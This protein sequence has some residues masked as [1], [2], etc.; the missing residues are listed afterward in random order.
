VDESLAGVM[1]D[2]TGPCP[3]GGNLLSEQEK[4]DMATFLERVSYPPARSRRIDDSLSRIGEGVVVADPDGG[5]PI[6]VGALEG[7]QDFFLDQNGGGNPDTCAD[8]NA[9]CHELPLGAATN[10]ETLQAFDA[11]T[12]RGMTDR[13]LQFSLGPAHTEELLGLLNFGFPPQISP[14]EAPI[15]WDPGQGFREITTFGAA[16]AI[17]EPIYGVRP[18]ST[19]PSGALGRQVTLNSR[20]T[21]PAL[22][23]E[24]EAL[25]AELEAADE[26]GV[27]NLRGS[28]LRNGQIVKLSYLQ[29]TDQYK[30]GGAKLSRAQ[31]IAEAQT[32]TL[33]ATLTAHLRSGVSESSPQ[34]LVAPVGAQCDTGPNTPDPLLPPGS[35][36][37]FEGSHVADG[38]AVFLNGRDTGL[39]VAVTG[40]SSSCSAT[41]GQITTQLLSVTGLTRTGGTDLLQIRSANGLLSNELP[42]AP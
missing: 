15:Q 39:T 18:L 36:F 42:L 27:V 2:Q 14:L 6:Q 5:N 19:G 17:F 33:L 9:G 41:E 11:P 26:R 12:M 10:S 1:C 8:S 23:A 4:D 34:P 40:T 16:F 30:V 37:Q 25:L 35:S 7:F 32:P 31:L 3:P 22:Q 28:G 38:D 24:T 13:F 29:D 20:T 21:G